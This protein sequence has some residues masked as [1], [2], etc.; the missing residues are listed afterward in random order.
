M[1]FKLKSLIW[2]VKEKTLY[3]DVSFNLSFEECINNQHN[4][5]NL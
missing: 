4:S 3:Q 5:K 2:K 1:N